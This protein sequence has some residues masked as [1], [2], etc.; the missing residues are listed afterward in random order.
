MVVERAVDR[1]IPDQRRTSGAELDADRPA[2]AI[3]DQRDL[4]GVDRRVLDQRIERSL[5]ARPHQRTVLVVDRG[6]RLHFRH[7]LRQDALAVAEKVGRE[8]HVSELGPGLGET[9]RLRRHALARMHH[10]HRRPLA[11]DGVVV[12]QITFELG[13]AVNVLDP[14][15]LELGLCHTGLHEREGGGE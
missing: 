15:L 12:D 13:V 2:E 5:G 10:Q 9:H 14:F 11:G 8:R 4:G 3:A 7:I 1:D 6:L